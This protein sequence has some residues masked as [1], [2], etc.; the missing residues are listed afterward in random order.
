M[1]PNDGFSQLFGQ[2]VMLW[3]MGNGGVQIIE[4]K[5]RVDITAITQ[6]NLMVVTKMLGT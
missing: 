1:G 4:A 2:Y 3:R 5:Q 6:Q